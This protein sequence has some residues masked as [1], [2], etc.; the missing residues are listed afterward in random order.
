MADTSR[1]DETLGSGQMHSSVASPAH[2]TEEKKEE[3][4]HS[5]PLTRPVWTT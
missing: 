3:L 1:E 5:S 4:C 2:E